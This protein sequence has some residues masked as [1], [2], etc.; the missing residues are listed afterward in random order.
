LAVVLRLSPLAKAGA[1]I[2]IAGIGLALYA[3]NAEAAWAVPVSRVVM[4]LGF[5][6]YVVARVRMVRGRRGPSG[7]RAGS[8]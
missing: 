8:P 2:F 3:E 4:V 5:V 6:L 1:T 7:P